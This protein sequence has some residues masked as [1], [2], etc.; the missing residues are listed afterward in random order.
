M[1]LFRFSSSL[2]LAAG[3]DGWVAVLIFLCFCGVVLVGCDDAE[4]CE[5]HSRGG[6]AV[7]HREDVAAQ[8]D[9]GEFARCDLHPA[10]N[11]A[12]DEDARGGRLAGVHGRSQEAHDRREFDR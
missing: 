9:A 6:A 10:V 5:N 7:R 12:R 4:V 2:M 8:R 1:V 11:Q 3:W